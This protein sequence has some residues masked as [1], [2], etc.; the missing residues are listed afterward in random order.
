MEVHSHW[1]PLHSLKSMAVEAT[2]KPSVKPSPQTCADV[3]GSVRQLV[4]GF[5]VVVRACAE[6]CGSV[7]KFMRKHVVWVGARQHTGLGARAR[8]GAM[9]SQS[10]MHMWP[11]M[12]FGVECV[13]LFVLASA[14]DQS[15]QQLHFDK[16]GVRVACA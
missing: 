6:V 3:R 12:Y 14:I 13:L 7:S 9:T 2:F 16:D 8:A 1:K 5:C 4:C 11:L 15:G 10:L